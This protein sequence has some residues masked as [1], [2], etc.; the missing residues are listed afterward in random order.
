[1]IYIT[2]DTHG[3]FERFSTKRLRKQGMEPGEQDYVIVCG[4]FGLCWKRNKTFEYHCKYFAEKKYTILWVQG[5]HENY[6][7]GISGRRMAWWK[8]QAYCAGQGYSFGTGA[9]V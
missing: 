9:G 1:M 2:G 3:E 4:D 6:D 8:S 7:S 5:N